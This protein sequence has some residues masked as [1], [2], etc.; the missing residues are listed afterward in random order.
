MGHNPFSKDATL[1]RFGVPGLLAVR[2]QGDPN[3]VIPSIRSAMARLEPEI[4]RDQ[5]VTMESL[6]EKELVAPKLNAFLSS[7]FSSVATVLAAIGLYGFFAASVAERRPELGLRLA[8]GAT[9]S[10][11]LTMIWK[12][13]S[14]L[15]T[16][17]ILVGLVAALALSR[18]LSGF[19]FGVEPS[20]PLTY[21]G[22]AVFVALVAL[23]ATYVPANRAGRVDPGVLLRE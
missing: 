13:M 17:G 14:R 3:A 23:G 5:I 20:D 12:E 4:P 11:L 18:L 7:F 10:R 21:A 16:A 9:P 22:V 6:F 15:A 8:L 2:A 1:H 19:L